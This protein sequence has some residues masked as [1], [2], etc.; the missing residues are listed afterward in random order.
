MRD[1]NGSH[2][3]RVHLSERRVAGSPAPVGPDRSGCLTYVP[4]VGVAAWVLV[5]ALGTQL[6]PWFLDNLAMDSGAGLPAEA[7]FLQAAPMPF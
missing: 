3:E 5:V 6:V 2:S 1:C 4:L 7:G